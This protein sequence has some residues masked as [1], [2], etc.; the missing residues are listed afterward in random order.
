MLCCSQLGRDRPHSTELH[1]WQDSAVS[2]LKDW[3]WAREDVAIN[4][5]RDERER[6]AFSVTRKKAPP[7]ATKIHEKKNSVGP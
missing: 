5:L 7:K 6:A 3:R 1:P 4:F 2:E